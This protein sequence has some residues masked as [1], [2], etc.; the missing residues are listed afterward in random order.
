MEKKMRVLIAGESWVVVTTHIKGFDYMTTST[1]E[2]AVEWLQKALEE[3][4]IGVDF[5]P[6]HL[7][8]RKFPMSMEELKLYQVVILSDIGANTLLLHPDTF[9]HSQTTPNRLDLLHDYVQEGGGLMMIGGYLSFTG[10]S[11]KANYRGTG[12]EKA[13]PVALLSTDDRVEV[14][15]GFSPE[16]CNP[17]HPILR[18]IQGPWP[19]LLGYNRVEP[20]PDAAVLLKY[21]DDPIVA[22]WQYGRG[23]AAVFTSD[24]ALHWGSPDFLDWRGYTT[25]FSQM[26]RW[27]AQAL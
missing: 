13:L 24:C 9:L 2:E 8:S 19:I 15:Q 6:N 5:L 3:S 27:L 23:R 1:Y 4:G 11:G 16:I 25:F 14:P 20:K 10:L 18:G 22:A 26:V 17:T 7:A 12:V 21:N